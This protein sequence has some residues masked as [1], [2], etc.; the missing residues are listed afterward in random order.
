MLGSQL[1][2][3]FGTTNQHGLNKTVCIMANSR[4]GDIVGAKI[5][6]SLKTVS[7]VNDFNFYGYGG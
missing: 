3:S 4:P 7:G 2:K 1:K 6:S 5:M